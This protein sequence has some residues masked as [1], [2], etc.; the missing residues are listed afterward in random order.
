MASTHTD[1]HSPL[2]LWD[3]LSQQCLKILSASWF[4]LALGCVLLI[5]L[6]VDE[7]WSLNGLRSCLEPPVK[8]LSSQ[9]TATSGGLFALANLALEFLFGSRVW[10]HRLFSFACL[11]GLV[12]VVWSSGR[13]GRRRT[14]LAGLL[15]V[16]PL[17]GLP[18][19]AEE[20]TAALGTSSAALLMIGAC[21][22][23]SE[24]PTPEI[25]RSVLCG[26]LFGL[27]AASRFELV[28]VA[29]VV[30]AV[31]SLH[32]DG[33]GRL[34]LRV[35]A[36]ALVMVAIALCLF[37]ANF[38]V[39]RSAASRNGHPYT[40]TELRAGTGTAAPSGRIDHAGLMNHV[41][42]AQDF[43]PI[44]LLVLASIA[45]FWSWRVG[46]K[47]APAVIRFSVLM[48][49]L[50]WILWAAWI[51]RAPI[52]HIR[53][54]WPSLVCFAIL[55]GLALSECHERALRLQR[56]F[57]AIACQ[58]VAL[59]LVLGGVSCTFR[60]LVFGDYDLLSLERARWVSTVS[61]RKFQ[62]IQNQQAVTNHLKTLVPSDAT[63]VCDAQ[64]YTF[65]YLTHR[66]VPRLQDFI[67]SFRP[68]RGLGRVY[69]VIPPANDNSFRRSPEASLWFA[70]H[71]RLDAQFGRYS[72]YELPDGLPA[73]PSLLI[74]NY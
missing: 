65:R 20:G 41:F 37:A 42:I 74:G 55:G 28:I 54:L 23:W 6:G 46:P 2:E 63:I 10:V 39:M 26:L 8:D 9:P 4:V 31:A 73:D 61:Y 66:P 13:A 30:L 16:A 56:P 15:A 24:S 58:L 32:N 51:A 57:P 25:G 35:P 21:L 11:L 34:R 29:P 48:L 27:A 60:S 38:L 14:T 47:P 33:G 69:L 62:Y 53:Y 19:T 49:V 18:G 72:V 71:S 59:G 3:N 44:G 68:E 43:C 22:V 67:K 12:G 5:A 36:H 17:L 45:P 52:P 1:C 50:G 70:A 40:I 64:P 7:A